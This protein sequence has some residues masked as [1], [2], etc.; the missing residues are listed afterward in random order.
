MK[1]NNRK[2]GGRY[3]QA[4]AF[5][6]EQS[7][8]EIIKCNYRCKIGEIDLIAKEGGYLVFCEVKYRKDERSNPL[9]AVNKKKQ[10]TI[11]KCAQWYLAEH[12]LWDIPCRFDVIGIAGKEIIL[13]KNAFMQ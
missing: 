1:Q 10:R 4:A 12:N 6:L 7:G 9:E 11:I 8:Y 5:Y 2:T 3:E 13:L